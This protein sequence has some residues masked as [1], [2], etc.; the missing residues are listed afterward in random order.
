MALKKALTNRTSIGVEMEP[1][2]S[3][4]LHLSLAQSRKSELRK[5]VIDLSHLYKTGEISESAFEKL[6]E[7]ACQS[8]VEAEVERRLGSYLDQKL[9][10]LWD[11]L[12]SDESILQLL[13]ASTK[14]D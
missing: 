5:V 3:K 1:Y 4:L 14:D 10:Q 13:E 12:A 6:A 9:V 11:R 7:Y 8:F 2:S